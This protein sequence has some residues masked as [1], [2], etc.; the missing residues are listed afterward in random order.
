MGSVDPIC[1]FNPWTGVASREGRGVTKKVLDWVAMPLDF[2]R[3]GAY[4]HGVNVIN[5]RFLTRPWVPQRVILFCIL[6][7]N[8]RSY[9]SSNS[10]TIRCLISYPVPIGS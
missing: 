1:F 5:Q 10:S 3:I 6:R 9:V 8:A 4:L 7:I 2:L